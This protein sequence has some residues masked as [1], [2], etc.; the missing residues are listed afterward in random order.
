M[1]TQSYVI[2]NQTGLHARPA[3]LFVKTANQ[4]SSSIKVRKDDEEG[5]A[6]SII[7]VLTLGAGI[8]ATISISASGVDETE[9]VQSLIGL[10]DTFTE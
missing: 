1:Y 3:S 6:K 2:K 4:F 7:S 5:D 9:A 8:G 10:M